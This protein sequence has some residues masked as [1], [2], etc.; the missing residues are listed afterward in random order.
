MKLPYETNFYGIILRKI[1]V[2][3]LLVQNEVISRKSQ[4]QFDIGPRLADRQKEKCRPYL[5]LHKAHVL[6]RNKQTAMANFP[7]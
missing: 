3:V 4:S 6:T 2:L 7:T 5:S 1:I